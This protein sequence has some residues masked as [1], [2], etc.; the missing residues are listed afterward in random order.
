MDIAD[1]YDPNY[2]EYDF[3]DDFIVIDSEDSEHFD[4]SEDS[5]DD[6]VD[7]KKNGPKCYVHHCRIVPRYNIPGHTPIYCAKHAKIGMK[8]NPM[9]KCQH[10]DCKAPAIYSDA[11]HKRHDGVYCEDDV[12]IGQDH[13]YVSVIRDE[14]LGCG[15]ILPSLVDDRCGQCLRTKKIRI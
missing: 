14:C 1:G 2:E 8:L 9:K 7:E 10:I 3:S 12:P 4:E 15:K 11:K 6:S 13:R 5:D